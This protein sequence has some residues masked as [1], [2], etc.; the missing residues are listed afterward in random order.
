ML[1]EGG[2]R[3]KSIALSAT[4]T[5]WLTCSS[6][7]QVG[8]SERASLAIAP[9]TT[10]SRAFRAVVGARGARRRRCYVDEGCSRHC[11]SSRGRRVAA[12]CLGWRPPAPSLAR[13]PSIAPLAVDR[14]ALTAHSLARAVVRRSSAVSGRKGISGAAA[15]WWMLAAAFVL[16]AMPA[17][18]LPSVVASRSEASWPRRSCSCSCA[19]ASLCSW[20][21][22]VGF[23]LCPVTG[24]SCARERDGPTR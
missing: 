9:H 23:R 17:G 11:C 4:T 20:S 22:S 10:R 12:W 19:N 24:V 2:V 1:P 8:T 3:V 6:V 14:T 15:G 18:G 13:S 5:T 16:S 21:A 7:T